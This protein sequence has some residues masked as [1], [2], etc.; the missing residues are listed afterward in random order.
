M[1]SGGSKRMRKTGPH[2]PSG[3]LRAEANLDRCGPA[4]VLTLQIVI[5]FADCRCA[6]RIC[7]TRDRSAAFFPRSSTKI[8]HRNSRP[9]RSQSLT[10]CRLA[11]VVPVPHRSRPGRRGW[12][13]TRTVGLTVLIGV[14]IAGWTGCAGPEDSAEAPAAA[15]EQTASDTPAS[16]PAAESDTLAPAL[17]PGISLRPREPDSASSTDSDGSN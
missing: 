5:G 6:W 14:F 11:G 3:E 15:V 8:M 1:P 16:T 7:P 10:P 12:L 9:R 4:F 2:R 17:P 13:P